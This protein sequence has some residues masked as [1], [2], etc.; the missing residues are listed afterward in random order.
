MMLSRSAKKYVMLCASGD[1][2]CEA[3]LKAIT[4]KLDGIDARFGGIDARFDAMEGSMRDHA[5]ATDAKIDAIDAKLDAK[6][7]A[8]EQR[9]TEQIE[10]LT[11]LMK[12]SPIRRRPR[13]GILILP[14]QR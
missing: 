10:T 14:A 4:R 13:H 9:I 2:N 5:A 11:L 6:L 7:N 3:A 8:M 1:C 12:N